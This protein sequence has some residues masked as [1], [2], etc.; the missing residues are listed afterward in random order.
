MDNSVEAHTHILR[1]S[2][3]QSNE[4]WINLAFVYSLKQDMTLDS[5][6]SPVTVPQSSEETSDSFYESSEETD[7]DASSEVEEA[8]F[9][10]WMPH[11]VSVE[12]LRPPLCPFT[13]PLSE[14]TEL[15]D[16]Y[17]VVPVSM[18]FVSSDL[19]RP[20]SL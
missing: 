13:S 5:E 1:Q 17:Y 19:T 20:R 10:F 4:E 16:T 7:Q 15:V 8:L 11:R 18:F 2:W 14:F 12:T 3:P 9:E 6:S